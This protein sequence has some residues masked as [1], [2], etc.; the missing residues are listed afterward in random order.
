MTYPLTELHL[1]HLQNADDF[2][3]QVM[4]PGKPVVIRKIAADW[5]L[6]REDAPILSTIRKFDVG[7]DVELFRASSGIGRYYYSEGLKDFD[8]E[9]ETLPLADAINRITAGM[10]EA[11]RE[12]LYVGSLPSERYLPGLGELTPLGLIP[13]NVHPRFW[14]GHASHIAC[15]YDT[16][17]NLACV[18][19]GRRRF[20]LFPPEAISD[21]YVGPIDFTMA[22]QPVGLAV[23]S[24]PGD[25]RF[26]RFERWREEALVAELEPG[27]GIYIPKLWWHQVEALADLNVLVNFW[28]DGFS[29]GPAQPYSALLLA[30]LTIAERPH[31]ERKAWKAW[32][33]HYVFRESRHPL[34]HIP[35]ERRGILGPLDNG[36]Y[37]RLRVAIMRMLRAGV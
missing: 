32:F 6:L 30:L 20:T 22:G 26:E 4:I 3:Q 36:N 21:L 11:D 13:R 29:A 23:A 9:R 33:D 16:L 5:P 27:D 12:T 34:E 18:A 25:P 1:E 19:E 14:I 15:H 8:F 10:G 28:W 35:A 37:Q 17:D 24:E 2:R 31:V 7:K